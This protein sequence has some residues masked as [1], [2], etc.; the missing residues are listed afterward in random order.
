MLKETKE[1]ECT[2]SVWTFC[3]DNQEEVEEVYK[4]FLKDKQKEIE[5]NGLAEVFIENGISDYE[6]IEKVLDSRKEKYFLDYDDEQD[7]F[8]IYCFS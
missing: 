1:A 4:N 2:K 3:E 6:V 5:E 8:R 7:I